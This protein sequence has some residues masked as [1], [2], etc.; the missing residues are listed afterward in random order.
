VTVRDEGSGFTSSDVENPLGS[1][2]LY[3]A[4]GRGIYLIKHFVDEMSHNNI[5][6]EITMV[7]K[8]GV[9]PAAKGGNPE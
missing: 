1:A 5:G 4:S 7:K 8:R 2:N 3:K 6:N 9:R